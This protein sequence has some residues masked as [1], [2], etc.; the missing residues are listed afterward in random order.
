MNHRLALRPQAL[1]LCGMLLVV[2]CLL[3]SACAGSRKAVLSAQSHPDSLAQ[4]F[5]D[6]SQ[7]QA[8]EELVALCPTVKEQKA[9]FAS[10]AQP[11]GKPQHAPSFPASK[12]AFADTVTATAQRLLGTNVDF[13]W[14]DARFAAF[15]AAES[16]RVLGEVVKIHPY[17]LQL[18]LPYGASSL[19]L[20]LWEW[21]GRY[22]LAD[23]TQ[24]KPVE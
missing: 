3:V 20:T 18:A 12:Q 9:M 11:A 1:R 24:P 17:T 19:R 15:S 5:L 7:R 13:T 23:F 14:Q 10:M 6:I 4:A 8:W 16:P 21:Q 22:F 2:A